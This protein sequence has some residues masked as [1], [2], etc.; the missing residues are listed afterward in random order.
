M[1][2]S[3]QGE[4]ATKGAWLG[5]AAPA[6]PPYDVMCPT[7]PRPREVEQE[8]ARRVQHLVTNTDLGVPP[9]SLITAGYQRIYKYF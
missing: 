7:P 9:A 6:T 1:F 2:S 4:V 3:L 8:L 5:P